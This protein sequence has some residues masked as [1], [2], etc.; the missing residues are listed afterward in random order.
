[1][2]KVLPI[3]TWILL[4]LAILAICFPFLY[5]E[6][7]GQLRGDD[8]ST[9]LEE[10]VLL[11]VLILL[12]LP[13]GGILALVSAILSLVTLLRRPKGRARIAPAISLSL[14]AL[15]VLPLLAAW[16]SGLAG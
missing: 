2:K 6:I 9:P 11:V 5:A 16:V 14:S 1:M 8:T 12:C 15:I 4:V 3:I 7:N 10:G 13:T